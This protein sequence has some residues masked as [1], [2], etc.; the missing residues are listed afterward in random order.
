MKF[1]R[2]SN[3]KRAIVSGM[4]LKILSMI[5]PFFMRT[6]IIY[7]LGN[8]YLGLSSLFT[9]ILNALNLAEL[10]IGSALVFA[11]YKP[12]AD[13][14]K[15]KV[16][17][18][19]NVYRYAYY[20][21]GSVILI[22][23]LLLV[24]FLPD[25][26]NGEYPPEVN[27][28]IVYLIHLA[29]TVSNYFFL[30]YRRSILNAYQRVD[31][32]NGVSFGIDVFIY[33]I[34][35]IVL[36]SFHNYYLYLVVSLIRTIC[37]NLVI[38][39][40]TKKKFSD[41]KPQGSISKEER[42][43]ILRKTAALVGHQIGT[44]V[45]T[46][47]DNILLSAFIGLNIVAVY[48]NYFHIFTAL[49][50]L[51]LMLTNGL[52]SIVGN[53]IVKKSRSDINGLFNDIHYYIALGVCFCC[54]CLLNMYQPFIIAW[55]G[56][57]SLLPFSSVI[58]FTLYFFIIKIKTVGM[59]F[60]NAAGIWEKD[61]LKPYIQIV[62]D[63]VIDLILL[64]TIGVNGAIISSIACILFG[65]IY[66]T[67]VVFKYC[68]KSSPKRFCMNTGIYFLATALSCIA[69][70][71]LCSLP[72]GNGGLLTVFFNFVVSS[73]V[74]V[75]VFVICTCRTKEFSHAIKFIRLKSR[76]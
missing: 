8:L 12:V 73:L 3:A 5:V 45:V 20:V 9:S 56:E 65:F 55:V 59:L 10:G 58:L 68:L 15:K 22:C 61:A 41:I 64:R 2:T 18:L 24:P 74:S 4:L 47:V 62:I 13:D 33:S 69:A 29:S 28:Y 31:I 42:K 63:L 26:I 40:I 38:W 1:N 23:G 48:N 51:F 71:M 19:L 66:E 17:A 76:C 25:I 52:T 72:S 16:N 60:K 39:L 36:L 32:I 53:Y 54:T 14:D 6:L 44:V 37:L 67:V 43:S 35:V 11:M 50:G 30:G 34:Q 70:M 27:I 21:I 46:S 75:F 57:E 49:S 7:T